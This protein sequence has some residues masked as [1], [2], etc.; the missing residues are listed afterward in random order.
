M[1]ITAKIHTLQALRAVA[2]WL[3]ITD[4]AILELSHNA[5]SDPATHL[6]WTLGSVG[7]C[8]FFV[9][10]GFVM[11]HISWDSFDLPGVARNFFKRR[12]VR[13]VP[14]YWAATLLALAYHHVS[15]THGAD[16]GWPEL[17]LSL[18]FIPY[19]GDGHSWT[20]ILPQGWTLSYEMLFYSIFAISLM[21][22]R[23]IALSAVAAILVSF[24]GVGRFIPEGSL[25][26]LASPIVLW[27]ILGMGLAVIWR[28]MRL[29]EPSWL[30]GSARILEPW[31]DASYSTYLSHGFV[32]TMLLRLWTKLVG[33]PSIWII[34][35]SLAV[36]TL[37][38]W[39][40]HISLERPLLRWFTDR[41]LRQRDAHGGFRTAVVP[42]NVVKG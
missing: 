29:F 15:A 37:F 36:A 20:P 17:A 41:L 7:V 26:T 5:L 9:L 22:P 33:E 14:L 42:R 11:V 4:H 2:A 39:L 34:P 35:V 25:A 30:L 13:V 6:A 1:R 38:G 18:A 3:V 27:F 10:S 12:L 24:V 32:L 28:R 19:P 23:G 31:G 8:L 21:R 16:A 40:V